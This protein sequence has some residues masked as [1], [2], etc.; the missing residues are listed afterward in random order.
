VPCREVSPSGSCL[1]FGPDRTAGLV[2][3]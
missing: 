3:R 2:F 1:V